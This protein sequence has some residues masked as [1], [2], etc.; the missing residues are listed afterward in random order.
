MP[1]FSIPTGRNRK[2]QLAEA[3]RQRPGSAAH[4]D[5]DWTRMA[6]VPC[7][8]CGEPIGDRTWCYVDHPPTDATMAHVVCH[9]DH[10]EK[11][12]TYV[13][14][15]SGKPVAVYALEERAQDFIDHDDHPELCE[16]HEVESA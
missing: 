4:L 16:I 5:A 14:T 8:Y 13:V 10:E 2:R 12:I 3:E 6:A 1:S 9:E 15:R 11:K 7:R